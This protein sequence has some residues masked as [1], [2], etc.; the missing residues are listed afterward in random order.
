MAV[1]CLG[2]AVYCFAVAVPCFCCVAV[3]WESEREVIYN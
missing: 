2:V 1:Q 3:K